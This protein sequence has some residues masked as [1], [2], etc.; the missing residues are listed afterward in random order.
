MIKGEYLKM[1]ISLLLDY[2]WIAI[3]ISAVMPP[4]LSVIIR[5]SRKKWRFA[6]ACPL[7][8]NCHCERSVAISSPVERPL[9]SAR[10]PRCSA[11]RDD[12][13]GTSEGRL[14]FEDLLDALVAGFDLGS[15]AL[16]L[17]VA[18]LNRQLETSRVAS[19]HS[20]FSQNA[21]IDQSVEQ[22]LQE[23][24]LEDAWNPNTIEPNDGQD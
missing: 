7:S 11:P 24:F 10:S 3:C 16:S 5:Y 19:Q 15:I 13:L 23:D 20:N 14:V 17:R 12:K 9:D 6:H 22:V 18:V 4:L 2:P 21:G 8:T 1:P